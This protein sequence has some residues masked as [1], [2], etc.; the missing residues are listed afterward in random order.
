MTINTVSEE[1][2]NTRVVK[3][4]KRLSLSEKYNCTISNTYIQ[5]YPDKPLPYWQ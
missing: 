2:R 4:V 5:I 1:N 3:K